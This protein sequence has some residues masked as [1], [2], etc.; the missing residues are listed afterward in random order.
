MPEVKSAFSVY[1]DEV[2]ADL[3]DEQD[4]KAFEYSETLP[5]TGV[6]K[7]LEFPSGVKGA[8]VTL[9]VDTV[10]IGQIEHTNSSLAEVRNNSAKWDGW[11]LGVV[12]G[13]I[14]DWVRPVTAIRLENKS[15]SVRMEA[16]LQ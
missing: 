13:T 11:P 9:R 4:E 3:D 16:R 6:G 12:S 8:S 1:P 5:G 7:A 2:R 10:G 15:G 14:A